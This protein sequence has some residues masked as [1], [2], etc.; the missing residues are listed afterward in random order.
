MIKT[1]KITNFRGLKDLEIKDFKRFNIFVGEN[2]CGKTSILE[3]IFMCYS[4]E[5]ANSLIRIQN[6]RRTM[7][8]PA[9]L[10]SIFYN[11]D[12]LTPVKI[13][14]N[15]DEK[16]IQVQIQP[17]TE[18]ESISQ[19][20]FKQSSMLEQ[21]INGLNFTR[22]HEKKEFNSHF[23]IQFNGDIQDSTK[24]DEQ[25]PLLAL[26]L[27]S[28]I[29]QWGLKYFIDIVRKEKKRDE[30]LGYLRLFDERI[31]DIETQANSVLVNLK[32][33]EKLIDINFLGEGFKK[34]TCI[35]A[36]ML[37][38]NQWHTR[39]CVCIDEIEN[40]LHFSSTQKL[41]KS[42]LKLSKK[43]DF[44]FFFTTHSLEFLDIARKILND[45]SKIFKVALTEK[46]IKTYSY[47]QNGE[48]YF[49]L[50]R[51]DPRGENNEN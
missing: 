35:L 21:N 39:F 23:S 31:I 47:S 15:Y 17:K 8:I 6:F 19:E 4:Q 38:A 33:I 45:E 27:P 11:F 25:L 3:A 40:G 36:L 24:S 20:K 41:L 18:S 28:D 49:T 2:S 50:D 43:L 30:L 9:N 10:S 13:H 1:I 5:E 7:V 34:Y 48:A 32:N 37:A 46:G 51:I 44:Q 14:S 16:N 22:I 26:Y 12:F 42:I 29:E